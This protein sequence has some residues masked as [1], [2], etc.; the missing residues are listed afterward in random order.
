[1]RWGKKRWHCEDGWERGRSL[2]PLAG[3]CEVWRPSLRTKP[4]CPHP[5]IFFFLHLSGNVPGRGRRGGAFIDLFHTCMNA[6]QGCSGCWRFVQ[7][8]KKAMYVQVQLFCDKRKDDTDITEWKCSPSSNLCMFCMCSKT[9]EVK[10]PRFR[11]ENKIRNKNISQEITP[12]NLQTNIKGKKESCTKA[13][14]WTLRRPGGK[15]QHFTTTDGR[16]QSI[17]GLKVCL[18]SFLTWNEAEWAFPFEW[19]SHF[20]SW[21]KQL[22][23]KHAS[24]F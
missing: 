22:S 4:E 5:N 2:R 15:I 6:V 3:W 14:G 10:H 9:L 17:G 23:F 12:Q 20:R 18:L 21:E 16:L 11:K 8:Q 13:F 19:A 24:F 1:M 7:E